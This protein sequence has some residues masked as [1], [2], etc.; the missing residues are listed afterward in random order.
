MT[1]ARRGGARLA[2]AR[3]LLDW[4][5]TGRRPAVPRDCPAE[6]RQ[7]VQDL[8]YT[9]V[10]RGRATRAA[11][12]PFV[13]K[14][15]G[16]IAGALL[17]TGAVQLLYMPEIPAFAAVDETVEAAKLAGRNVPAGLVNAV[18]RNLERNKAAAAERLAAEP[19]HVRESHPRR[20]VERWTEDF[21][22]EAAE[23][24]AK[25]DNTPGETWL[26][27]RDGRREKLERGRAVESLPGYAQGDFIVQDPSQA[28]AVDMFDFARAPELLD[29]CAAPGGKTIQAAFAGAR[30]TACEI[31]PGRR[32]TLEENIERTKTGKDVAILCEPPSGALFRNILVDA[33]CSNTGVMRKRPDARWNWS[34]RKTAQLAA[35]QAELLDKAAAFAAPG[36]TLVYSTCS[37]DPRE[38]REQAE[39]FLS[40]HG[41]FALV[42]ESVKLPHADGCDGSYAAAMEKRQ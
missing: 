31:N 12:G 34:E 19:L 6:S 33:P 38:N 41:D 25:F 11:L 42:R 29:L 22:A 27:H 35:L 23:K 26:L 40:R 37:I 18:L 13:S 28:D 3:A 7:F 30:V 24:I 21:G 4:M 15:P 8:L 32:R 2:A 39:A 20:L 14:W 16:G 1:A 10:K 9:S 36:A 17:E 5:E